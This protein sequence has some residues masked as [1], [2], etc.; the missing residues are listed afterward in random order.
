[1]AR[2]EKMTIKF[3]DDNTLVVD[4][5]DHRMKHLLAGKGLLEALSEG[6]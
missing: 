6:D 4:M 1:M 2:V 3:E 5:E